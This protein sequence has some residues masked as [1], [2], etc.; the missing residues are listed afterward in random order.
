MT[1]E[2]LFQIG[3]LQARRGDL[4]RAEQYII[5]ARA[6]GYDES[7]SV[8]WLVRVCVSAGRFHSA[9]GHAQSYLRRNPSNWRLRLVVASIYEALGDNQRAVR[10]LESVVRGAPHHALPHYRLAVLYG[11]LGAGHERAARHLHAYLTLSPA[12]PHA[13]EA[14]LL[15]ENGRDRMPEQEVAPKSG[16]L[17]AGSKQP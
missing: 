13:A 7:S 3:V 12:G 16:E 5:A 15:L 4:L 11:Q 2:E 14:R 17:V 10:E 1:S 8:Y 6:Q 9:L